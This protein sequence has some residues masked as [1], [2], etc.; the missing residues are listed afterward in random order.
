MAKEDVSGLPDVDLS[1]LD[2]T[3]Q[4]KD[5]ADDVKG[6]NAADVK[7]DVATDLA[8]FKNPEALLK[9]YKELQGAFTKTSQEKKDLEA[10][11]NELQEQISL[12]KAPGYTPEIDPKF[13][14]SFV[15]NPQA[16]IQQAIFQQRVVEFIEEEQD[17]DPESFQERYAHAQ[18]VLQQHPNLSKTVG[19]IKKAFKYAEKMRATKLQENTDK[20][21]KSVFGSTLTKDEIENLVLIAKGQ[22]PGKQTNTNAYMP[23]TDTASMR[24]SDRD[25]RPAPDA[26]IRSYVEKGDV[27]GVLDEMFSNL[28]AE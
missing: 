7:E 28:M 3:G 14:D 1:G 17:R 25:Q 6:D 15:E 23:D 19:G 8:Q 12:S 16:T 22:K 2:L 4:D 9:S 21:M 18:M 20:I 24:T 11:I 10:K 27:D 26:K 5:D 13:D